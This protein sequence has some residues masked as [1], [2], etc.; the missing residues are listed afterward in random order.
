MISLLA[1]GKSHNRECHILGESF[2]E[3]LTIILFVLQH[4]EKVLLVKKAD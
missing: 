3:S 1:Q 2:N 4:Q